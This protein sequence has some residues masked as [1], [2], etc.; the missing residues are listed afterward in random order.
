MTNRARCDPMGRRVL[1]AVCPA[2]LTAA[3]LCF[4]A[5]LLAGCGPGSTTDS[6]TPATLG[7]AAATPDELALGVAVTAPATEAELID[8]GIELDELAAERPVGPPLP[9]LSTA[10]QVLDVIGAVH[11]PTSDVSGQMNRLVGFP[12]VATPPGAEVREIRADIREAATGDRLVVT[13]EVLLG[14]DGTVDELISF[15]DDEFAG[16]GWSV[17][18]RSGLGV[19][20]SRVE[21]LTYLIP[22]SEYDQH[23]IE[24]AVI[25]DA[26]PEGTIGE[27]PTAERSM[28][29]LRFVEVTA[30]E[31]NRSSRERFEGWVGDLPLPA[32]GTITGAAIQTS[33]VG[34][35]SLHFSLALRYEGVTP[36]DIA[37]S[38]R[39]AL[40]TDDYSIDPQPSMGQTLD[41]WV[42]LDHP[43]FA[44]ARVSPHPYGPTDD[45][46]GTVVNVDARVEFSVRD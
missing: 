16:L 13:S 20:P 24:L 44:E 38:L 29:R 17:S 35:H 33:A 1:T 45:P 12:D 6:A 3:A 41:A 26:G 4:A 42:Y 14:A 46:Q 32:G 25:A 27:G 19:G 21:Q 39:A 11:G 23:D 36:A 30:I 7:S 5:V 22:D 10:E 8:T 31:G 28:V 40:P 15:Y 43:F 37:S 9:P 34:R 2:A 18:A